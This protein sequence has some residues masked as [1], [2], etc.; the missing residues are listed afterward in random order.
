M[1]INLFYQN[2]NPLPLFLHSFFL[3]FFA[4]GKKLKRKSNFKYFGNQNRKSNTSHTQKHG[5][6]I[7]TFIDKKEIVSRTSQESKTNTKNCE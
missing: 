4:L 5:Q 6:I 1:E 3:F 2:Q 7:K